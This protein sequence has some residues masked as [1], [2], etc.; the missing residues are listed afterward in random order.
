VS[1][2]RRGILDLRLRIFDLEQPSRKRAFSKSQIANP[3][4]QIQMSA[5][6]PQPR[7]YGATA[8]KVKSVAEQIH[9]LIRSSDIVQSGALFVPIGTRLLFRSSTAFG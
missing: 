3:K 7:D 1:R 2:L 9:A 8:P 5:F 4:S 6:V